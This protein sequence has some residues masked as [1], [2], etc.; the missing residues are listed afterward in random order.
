MTRPNK[1]VG[2]D[3]ELQTPGS[4]AR[5]TEQREAALE[6][7]DD[8]DLDGH[9]ARQ[10]MLKHKGAHGSGMNLDFPGSDEI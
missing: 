1:L 7:C 10:I 8:Q 3:L 4:D 5:V 6:I 2:Q 9:N